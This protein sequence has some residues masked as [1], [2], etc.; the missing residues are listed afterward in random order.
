MTKTFHTINPANGEQL[1]TYEFMDG[2]E[3]ERRIENC[4][5]AFTK[6]RTKSHE[7]RAEIIRN[8]GEGLQGHKDKLAVQ[9]TCEIGKLLSQSYE[10][11]DLCTAICAWTAE[12]GASILADEHRE[13]ES[14]RGIISHAPIGVIYGIQPWNYPAYQVIRYAIANLMAGNG[15]LLKHAENVTG[16][17][18]LLKAVFEEAGLPE[19]LFSV[20]IIDHD[21]SNRVIDHGLVRGVTL[22]GSTDAGREVGARVARALKKSVLELGSNDA[23]LVLED[24]DLDQAVT[25][26]VNGRT[27]NNGETCIAAKRFVVVEA[28]YDE[29]VEKFVKA[30][31]ELTVGDPT[32]AEFDI[33]P[34]AREDLRDNL[35]SQVKTSVER[36]AK[37]VTGGEIPSGEGYFYPP[38][39]LLNVSPGQP[40]YDDELFGPVAS[41]IK[42]ADAADA[43]RIANDSRFGLGGGILTGDR[44][45]AIKLATEEFDTG[46]VFINGFGLATPNMPFGGVKNSGYGREHGGYGIREFTNTKAVLLMDE[47]AV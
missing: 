24:A 45:R 2:R 28:V 13:L 12:H 46:M 36:G 44:E 23:Y 31:Q 10:E 4:H 34:M 38:T 21:Q 33:G 40:A 42:A 20:L 5:I 25:H 39:V 26:C 6:W 14:G 37:L 11:I 3:V 29:F 7:V 27:Y 41:V 19:H 32:D 35:H 30:M 47:E 17:G 15:V 18:L 8:I 22:T 43:V 1:A 16:T 9:M